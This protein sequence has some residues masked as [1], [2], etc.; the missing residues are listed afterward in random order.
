MKL[1]IATDLSASSRQMME[2]IVA[3]PWPAR[4]TA[5]ILH[6]VDFSPYT[7]GSELLKVAKRSS[8]DSLK[9]VAKDLEWSSLKIQTEVLIGYPRNAIPKYAKDWGADFIVVGSHGRALGRFLLGSVAQAV[10][11]KASCSVE[12]VRAR[13]EKAA[14]GAAMKVL[15][16]IDGSGCSKAAVRSVAKR[17]WPSGT[18]FKLL[19]VVP[20]F[21]PT[22]DVAAP[23][24]YIDQSAEAADI[25]EREAR[26]RAVEAVAEAQA[27]LSRAGIQVPAGGAPPLGDPR[28]V[29]LDE[30]K[31]WGADL[32][33][34]GS[35]GW[36][37]ID[38]IMLGSVS[39]S[40]AM[41]AP[42]SVEVIRG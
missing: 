35:H 14:R 21:M 18:S 42:C 11:R 12:I 4:S 23:Y 3:R 15:L 28:T 9:S 25:I 5:C 26:K 27:L 31:Q 24:F 40:V 1:L 8:E 32:I 22:M 30:A 17:P 33:V 6:V 41:H 29:I 39:E 34:V 37:G 2:A 19:S 36:R 38:R 20:P 7:L 16:A 13:P 10:V